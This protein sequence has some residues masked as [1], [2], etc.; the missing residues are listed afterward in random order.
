M[1]RQ[2]LNA[3]VDL[4]YVLANILN[5]LK[6]DERDVV[7]LKQLIIDGY[8]ELALFHLNTLKVVELTIASDNTVTLPEDFLYYSKIAVVISDR[9]HTLTR[10]DKIPLPRDYECGVESNADAINVALADQIP[11]VP[12]GYNYAFFA[13]T[14][15]NVGYYRIDP[16]RRLIILRGVFPTGTIILEYATIPIEVGSTT[17]IPRYVVPALRAYVMQKVVEYDLR[18]NSREKEARRM[19]YNGELEKLRM[20]ENQMTSDE[21]M[22]IINATKV[23]T[24]RR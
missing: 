6:A 14:G 22:D 11:P 23:Q 2:H 15:K 9:V 3:L 17:L 21:Y 4:E 12:H 5:S 7:Y 13:D 16:Q 20:I 10:D 8:S 24:V 18:I 1:E 19:A